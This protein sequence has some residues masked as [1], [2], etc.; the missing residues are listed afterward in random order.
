MTY[1]YMGD[2]SYFRVNA[3]SNTVFDNVTTTICDLHQQISENEKNKHW[4]DH[5]LKYKKDYKDS[6]V[7][8]T[9]EEK[10]Y[11]KIMD[12]IAENRYAYSINCTAGD[13]SIVKVGGKRTRS[14]RSGK[15]RKQK[16]RVSKKKQTRRKH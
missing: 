4:K 9:E 11:E 14:S 13:R 16:R 1:P 5:V 8:N 6:F 12:E 3:T 15:T 7:F 10:E 2:P